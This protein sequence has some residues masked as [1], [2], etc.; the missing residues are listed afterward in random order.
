MDDQ[1]EVHVIQVL[2]DGALSH[3]NGFFLLNGERLKF[4][5]VAFTAHGGP[6]VHAELPPET[7]NRLKALGLREKEIDQL[8][9]NLQ[10]KLLQGDIVREYEEFTYRKE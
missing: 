3:I 7:L 4:T 9:I 6:N 10:I 5:G 1:F 2:R 8:T